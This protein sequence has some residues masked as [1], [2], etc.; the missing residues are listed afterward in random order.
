M[1]RIRSV[2]PEFWDDRKIAKRASRDARLLYIALW[3]LADEWGRLNGDP[4]WIKG[5]VFSYDDDLDAD[6]IAKLLEELENPA[7]GTVVAYEADGDPYLFLPKLGKHQRLEPEKVNNGRSRLPAPPAWATSPRDPEP[8]PAAPTPPASQSEP[9]ADSSERRADSS[10]PDPDESESHASSS[11]LLY[12]MGAGSREHVAGGRGSRAPARA[13]PPAATIL[14]N[15]LLDEHLAALR[16]RPPRAV[17]ASLG[18][19][20]DGLLDEPHVGPDIIRLALKRLRQKPGLGPGALPS[21]ADEILQGGG[22]A[23]AS[24]PEPRSAADQRRADVAQLR[25]IDRQQREGHPP[26]TIQGSVIR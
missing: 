22:A 5:Q 10:G 13:A 7:L 19:R 2:K 14:G 24:P 17:I 25:E 23:R 15:Q 21:L 18:Q 6:A 3:N 12:V 9:R 16:A 11:A 4:Q 1:A 20:I 8:P 26:G